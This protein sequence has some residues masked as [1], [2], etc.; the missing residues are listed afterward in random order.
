MARFTRYLDYIDCYE[1]EELPLHTNPDYDYIPKPPEKPL[2]LLVV[3]FLHYFQEPQ[4]AGNATECLELMPKRVVGKLAGGKRVTAWDLQPQENLPCLGF[5]LSLIIVWP[6]TAAFASWWLAK[7]PNDLQN[8]FVPVNYAT[9]LAAI[10]VI[11]P[12][13]LQVYSLSAPR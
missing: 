5:G 11:I 7:H 4:C 13:V 3:E 10:C 9:S 1:T 12:E 2:T 8:A 6:S